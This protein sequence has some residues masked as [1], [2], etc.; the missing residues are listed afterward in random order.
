MVS[1]LGRWGTAPG[2]LHPLQGVTKPGDRGLLLQP[3][4]H[5]VRGVGW[6]GSEQLLLALPRIP[7]GLLLLAIALHGRRT[8]CLPGLPREVPV[9]APLSPWQPASST[10]WQRWGWQPTA[11]AS[12]TSMASS[13][14]RSGTGGRYGWRRVALTFPRTA[15]AL[16]PASPLDQ[17]E[18]RVHRH[19]LSLETAGAVGALVFITCQV[20]SRA[21]L[22]S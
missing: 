6:P 7:A 12:A 15:K 18:I 10:Q 16:N 20:F 2:P 11:T 13:T 19:S 9:S 4:Q 8:H 3:V 14:R 22:T 17:V 5:R 1:L 21:S